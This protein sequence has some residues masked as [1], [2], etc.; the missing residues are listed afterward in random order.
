M[1]DGEQMKQLWLNPNWSLTRQLKERVLIFKEIFL[2][3]GWPLSTT[4][5]SARQE[6]TKAHFRILCLRRKLRK[7]TLVPEDIEWLEEISYRRYAKALNQLE[8][9][10]GKCS[11]VAISYKLVSKCTSGY[12][13]HLLN[14][15]T[16]SY[17]GYNPKKKE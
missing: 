13:F 12:R 3:Q 11:P 8:Q 6:L 16:D 17:N 7:G 15:L 5:L 10:T 9:C 4:A 14:L 2:S 1:E